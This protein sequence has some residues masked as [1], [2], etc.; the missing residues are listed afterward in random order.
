[1]YNPGSYNKVTSCATYTC[2]FIYSLPLF[3]S[4]SVTVTNKYLTA[5]SPTIISLRQSFWSVHKNPVETQINPK[6]ILPW[7]EINLK[8]TV[9]LTI[10]NTFYQPTLLAI[11]KLFSPLSFC[12][13]ILAGIHKNKEEQK[14]SHSRKLKMANLRELA[15]VSFCCKSVK[16]PMLVVPQRGKHM[17]AQLVEA[18]LL[19][20]IPSFY[21]HPWL[22]LS[23]AKG[24]GCW[25]GTAPCSGFWLLQA[26]IYR[27]KFKAHWKPRGSIQQRKK[28]MV[29]FTLQNG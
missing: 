21:P 28:N 29:A 23:P 27:S 22:K 25:E 13:K 8:I 9:K 20:L 3:F 26:S 24:K 16:L 18:C 2:L 11:V 15:C 14:G 19:N 7:Q 6:H 5:H 10:K 1:M 17:E 12:L 4:S